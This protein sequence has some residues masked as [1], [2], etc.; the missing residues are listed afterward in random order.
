MEPHDQP[1]APVTRMGQVPTETYGQAHIQWLASGQASRARELML[2]V[3]TIA[4]GGASPPHRHPNCE[5][6]LHMLA[7]E[8]DQV[9]AG[10]PTV[11]MAAGDPITIPRNAKH[12]AINAGPTPATMVVVFSSP[13][14]ETIVEE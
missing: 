4:P 3:T 5:E 1:V 11:R 9:V 8:I 14:R 12:H 7:G 6:V 2:G 10:Q 13:Q